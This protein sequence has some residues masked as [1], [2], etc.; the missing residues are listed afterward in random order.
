MSVRVKKVKVHTII[1]EKDFDRKSQ[2]RKDF[3]IDKGV[4]MRKNRL[5]TVITVDTSGN[6]ISISGKNPKN[7]KIGDNIYEQ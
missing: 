2:K 4:L 5:D 6:V 7:T 3:E 1:E